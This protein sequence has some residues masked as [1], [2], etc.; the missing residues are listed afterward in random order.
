MGY[1]FESNG[2]KFEERETIEEALGDFYAS[3]NGPHADEFINMRCMT[4][5]VDEDAGGNLVPELDTSD[6]YASVALSRHNL[7]HLQ[8][9]CIRLGYGYR[10]NNGDFVLKEKAE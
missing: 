6:E 7:R 3:S 2:K 10:D 8:S 1:F 5:A 4:V 9:E